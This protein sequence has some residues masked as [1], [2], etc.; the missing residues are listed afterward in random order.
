VA[1]RL[2][3]KMPDLLRIVVDDEKGDLMSVLHRLWSVS[4]AVAMV[5][6]ET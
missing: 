3:W 6:D 5:Q 4:R 1:V 2:K